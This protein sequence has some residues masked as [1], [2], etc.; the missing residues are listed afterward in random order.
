MATS[1]SISN[2]GLYLDPILIQGE[3]VPGVNNYRAYPLWQEG[4]TIPFTGDDRW[5]AEAVARNERWGARA[6]L[7]EETPLEITH[8]MVARLQEGTVTR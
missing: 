3:R 6:L 2:D 4:E 5:D 8:R 1:T 7:R